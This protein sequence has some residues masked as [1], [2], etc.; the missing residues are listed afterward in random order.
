MTQKV[1]GGPGGLAAGH[2]FDRSEAYT[3]PAR[4][5]RTGSESRDRDMRDM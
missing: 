5:S 2:I 1:L 4:Q 3:N